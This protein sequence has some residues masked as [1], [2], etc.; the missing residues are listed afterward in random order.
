CMQSSKDPT[1]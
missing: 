1:F